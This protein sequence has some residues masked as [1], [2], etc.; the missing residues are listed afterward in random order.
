MSKR[1]DPFTVALTGQ[2]SIIL[3]V[4]TILAFVASYLLLR[5]YRRAVI[6]SMRRRSRSD[7]LETHGFIAPEP[8]HRPHDGALNFG[9][10]T[11][12]S[13]YGDERSAKLYRDAA[14]SI[15]PTALVH[16]IAGSVFA[17][18]TW[19]RLSSCTSS[20]GWRLSS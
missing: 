17:A 8:E 3:I 13:S 16:I 10:I 20:M 2:L 7:I 18:E 5:L 1:F 6:K 11:R 12:D 4:S 19:E 14:R 9:F 15:R